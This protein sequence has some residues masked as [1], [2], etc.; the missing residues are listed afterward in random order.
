[1][2]YPP[3][4]LMHSVNN[5]AFEHQD[6][7]AS[8][9]LDGIRL[10]V[11][12]MD[13]FKLYTKNQDV[14]SRFPELHNPPISK[15]TI[16]DGELIVVDEKGHPDFEAC[17]SRFHSRKANY[18]VQFCAFDILYCRGENVTGLPLEKRLE[19]LEAE[20]QETEH[21]SRMRIIHGNPV[22]LF[23]I[24]KAAGLEGIVLKKRDSKYETR[25]RP[26]EPG[27]KAIRSWAW[28]KVIN[29][30][31]SDVV[32]TGYSKENHHWL[33]GAPEDGRIKPLGTMELGITQKHRKEI[34][35][36]LG[37]SVVDENKKFVFVEPLITCRVRHRGYYK[38]GFM[39]LPVLDEVL[40]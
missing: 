36:R 38:S 23:E 40:S 9:K 2:F 31:S 3:M 20:M 28:Q 6:Y 18:K 30:S 10:L 14:T 1:M 4:L 5:E 27:S 37:C 17:L 33:I 32:I 7:L 16:L 22:Q 11:S 15:G 13:H 25:S 24:V 8:L 34:W 21:Y 19:L 35:P 26:C 39:R 29:Y 12:N